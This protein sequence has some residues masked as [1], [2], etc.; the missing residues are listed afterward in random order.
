[1]RCTLKYL[2]WPPLA[3]CLMDASRSRQST[4]QAQG[5]GIVRKL[6]TPLVLLG[7]AVVLMGAGVVAS[8]PGDGAGPHVFTDAGLTLQLTSS[9]PGVTFS[10]NTLV[11]PP[12]L[13]TSSS[14]A[15]LAACQFTISSTGDVAPSS[16]EVTMTVSGITPAQA[17]AKK[18]AVEPQPGTLVYFQTTSQMVYTFT[19][20]QLPATVDPGVVWG[21][22]AGAPLDNSDMGAM[23]SV[24]YT[25]SAVSVGG[26]TGSPVASK[27]PFESVGGATGAP[28]ETSTPPPTA[29]VNNSSSDNSSPLFALLICL[30]LGGSCLIAVEFQRRTIRR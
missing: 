11:C 13:I 15:N 16:L 9:M 25:V 30:L 8:A 5:R 19:G 4:F 28:G 7:L 27:A 6:A 20:A 23:V 17:S 1:M 12:M 18:F 2:V 21:A 14:G 10:G 26:A 3:G 29:S 22:N 24:T